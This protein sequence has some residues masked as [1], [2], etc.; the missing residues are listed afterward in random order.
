MQ[1]KK[2]S[3]IQDSLHHL[4]AALKAY[5]KGADPEG[6]KFLALTK[7]FEIAVEYAW[8]ELKR[9]VEDEGL[10]A[11][12]PKEAIRQA[13]KLHVIS[14]P[15]SWLDYINAR[16]NSVHDYFGI[17]EKDFVELIEAFYKEASSIFSRKQRS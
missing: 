3:K 12:S 14:N 10:E 6:L 13:A 11:P 9:K 1:S 4:G 5:K 2:T 17:P 7:A 16:N 15:E 8:K